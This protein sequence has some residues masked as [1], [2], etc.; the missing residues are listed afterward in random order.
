MLT[1]IAQTP[2]G[3]GESQLTEAEG[4]A[5]AQFVKRIGWSEM[6][7]N[8]IDDDEAYLMRDALS[9]LQKVLAESGFA[10]R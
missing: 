6:R 4:L 5:L 7:G 8:A 9:K 1:L 10:P 2:H 3:T